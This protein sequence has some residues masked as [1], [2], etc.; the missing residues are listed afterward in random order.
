MKG[1]GK[2]DK[3]NSNNRRNLHLSVCLS[4]CRYMRTLSNNPII[5]SGKG[6]QIEEHADG[7]KVFL[8]STQWQ[9]QTQHTVHNKSI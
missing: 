6:L 9:T 2:G 7:D 4:V 1:R 5:V 3:G 8:Y